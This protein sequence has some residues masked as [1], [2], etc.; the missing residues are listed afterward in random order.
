MEFILKL[1][2]AI[3]TCIF[4]VVL[5]TIIATTGKNGKQVTL[6]LTLQKLKQKLKQLIG[7]GTTAATLKNLVEFVCVSIMSGKSL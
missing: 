2:I 3:L 7:C 5:L 1:R 6:I 4:I